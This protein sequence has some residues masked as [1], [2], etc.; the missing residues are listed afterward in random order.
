M[1]RKV[2]QLIEAA[3]KAGSAHADA[4]AICDTGDSISIRNGA[5]E[6]IERED[7][8]GIGLRAFV[9]TAKGFAVATASTS[10]MS[11]QGLNQLATQVIA[12]A[13]ISEPDPDAVPPVGAEH[14]TDEELTGW[15]EQH[16]DSGCGWNLANWHWT[17]TP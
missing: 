16:P 13:R 17:M 6:S 10:D 15:S 11:E 3:A 1:N 7:A 14:P 5:V 4:L 12:M 8:Q 2:N 9:E